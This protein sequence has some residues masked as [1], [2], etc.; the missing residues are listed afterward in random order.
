MNAWPLLAGAIASEVL[1]TLAL[2]LAAA[3]RHRWYPLVA[4]C[5]LTAFVLLSAA[6]RFGVGIGVAYGVWTAAGV[7]LVAVF[8][9]LFFGERLSGRRLLGLGL[10][11]LGVVVVELGA[12]RG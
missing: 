10:I 9:H 4:G 5:Y 2:R 3:G 6:L 7:A 1:G 11:A 8:S 12:G